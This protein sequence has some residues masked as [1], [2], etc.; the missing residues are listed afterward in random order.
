MSDFS[1]PIGRYHSYRNAVSDIMAHKGRRAPVRALAAATA[2]GEP[3][4]YDLQVFDGLRQIFHLIDMYS[5]VLKSGH[6]LTEP[7]LIC[8]AAIAG[9][10]KIT[11]STLSKRLH[12]SQST[13]TGILDRLEKKELVVRTRDTR[14]R[15][16]VNLSLTEKGR[17]MLEAAP[18][19]IQ[20]GLV[21]AVAGLDQTDQRALADSLFRIVRL[22]EQHARDEKTSARTQ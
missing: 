1:S 8:L 13:V 22:L 6:S 19:P 11:A 7:Q 4:R 12:L 21:E 10:D 9:T 5:R 17:S 16:R 15:R 3:S 20:L 2:E 18:P 14:D